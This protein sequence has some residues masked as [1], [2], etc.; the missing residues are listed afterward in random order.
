MTLPFDENR[1][2]LSGS[3]CDYVNASWVDNNPSECKLMLAC[4]PNSLNL[5]AFAQAIV[6]TRVA[7]IVT[8]DAVT[9]EGTYRG[10]Q[11]HL[12]G[13]SLTLYVSLPKGYP[14]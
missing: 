14:K 10:S 1:V 9:T 4:S 6:Q 11:F 7:M 12:I 2:L 3:E 5:S 8:F 13:Q